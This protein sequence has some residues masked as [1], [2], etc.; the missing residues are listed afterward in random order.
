MIKE[1]IIKLMEKDISP[2]INK[3]VQYL[4]ENFDEN[5][6]EGLLSQGF[7]IDKN[8]KLYYYVGSGYRCMNERVDLYGNNPLCVIIEKS[9]NKEIL[10]KG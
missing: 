9:L 4:L 1:T 7:T 2:T 6:L 10:L 5:Q 8:I 3:N